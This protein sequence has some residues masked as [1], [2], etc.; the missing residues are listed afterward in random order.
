MTFHTPWYLTYILT[1]CSVTSRP[2]PKVPCLMY[3]V[4]YVSRYPTLRALLGQAKKWKCTIWFS[5]FM[6]R[7]GVRIACHGMPWQSPLQCHGTSWGAMARL[8]VSGQL[9]ASLSSNDELCPSTRRWLGTQRNRFECRLLLIHCEVSGGANNVLDTSEHTW[10]CTCFAGRIITYYMAEISALLGSLKREA[11]YE[12]PFPKIGCRLQEDIVLREW[13]DSFTPLSL[14]S[15]TRYFLVLKG[16][17]LAQ[18][19]LGR[20]RGSGKCVR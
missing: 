18:C 6:V 8:E 13:V 3:Y 16:S 12:R 14:P 10:Q 19:C 7:H 1:Y 17:R 20:A 5:I 15:Y 9:M 11:T 2:A 4:K